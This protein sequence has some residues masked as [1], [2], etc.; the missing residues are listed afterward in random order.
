MRTSR[1]KTYKG[2]VTSNSMD[3]TI[4]VKVDTY[5]SHKLYGKR[6]KYSKKFHA[7]DEKNEAN[8]G[9][10]V[11]I[12]ETRPLSKLKRFRLIE[13]LEKKESLSKGRGE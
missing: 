7:H 9:D 2:V 12:M 10:T 6:Y 4:T 1:R 13:I 5:R 3:K 11:S 8:I